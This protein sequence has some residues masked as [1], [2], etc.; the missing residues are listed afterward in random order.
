MKLTMNYRLKKP[1]S[2]DVVN[3]DDINYNADLL[4]SKIKE[5]DEKVISIPTNVINGEGKGSIRTL[6]ASTDAELADYAFA[7]GFATQA[8]GIGTH[9]EGYKT[10]A[11]GKY[12]HS[13]GYLTKSIGE[14]SHSAG[15][16]TTADEYCNMTIGMYNVV[17]TG[18]PSNYN[19]TNSAFTVGNGYF[20]ALSNAFRVRYD[21][22]VYASKTFNSNGADYGEYFEWQDG[23]IKNE[24]R[25]GKFVTLIGDR[26]KIASPTDE[27]I[28]GIVSA[29]PSII[30]N[31]YE[32]T[33]HDM[34]V[35]DKL[36]RVIYENID[37]ECIDVNEL[38][39]EVIVVKKEYR[40]K[41]NPVYNPKRKYTAR[42]SRKEWDVVG[43][44]GKLTVYDDGTC[45]V[46]S[47]CKVGDNGCATKSESGY[48]VIKRISN[49]I[50][51]V[52]FR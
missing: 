8:T 31:S 9:A 12:S 23:N 5:I 33:W 28:L 1:E 4:D 45:E 39:K 32:D 11:V 37:V 42:S 20:G 38:N 17:G 7:H 52:L 34:Y 13:A 50:I 24:D 47:F 30:G 29:N 22:N 51:Q 41:L 19:G 46:N 21:G 25:A 48:R 40:P 35:R 49:N 6:N 27:Y 15:Y 43:M 36:G 10:K 3:I 16:S 18:T 44:L 14:N 2:S 26:I